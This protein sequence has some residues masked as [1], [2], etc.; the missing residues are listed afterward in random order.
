M[1]I[2]DNWWWLIIIDDNWPHFWWGHTSNTFWFKLQFWSYTFW[3]S[4][5][6]ARS[7]LDIS[8]SLAWINK[9]R[10]ICPS[11]PISRVSKAQKSFLE[12]Q[13]HKKNWFS[14]KDWSLIMIMTHVR[15][16][17]GMYLGKVQIS[18]ADKF[19]TSWHESNVYC[20]ELCR[21]CTMWYIGNVSIITIQLFDVYHLS[22]K[23]KFYSLKLQN[24]S[25]YKSKW[26]SS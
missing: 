3:K 2:Y 26:W 22:K 25:K 8:K 14:Q 6:L 23:N 15:L 4:H 7:A 24:K 13:K 17:I 9:F 5:F 18:Y 12:L 19:L 1:T 21:L 11:P 10:E 20:L 16:E